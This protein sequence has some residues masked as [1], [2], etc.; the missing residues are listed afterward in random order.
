MRAL[1]V[2]RV[3][4]ASSTTSKTNQYGKTKQFCGSLL[5]ESATRF[6]LAPAKSGA[7]TGDDLAVSAIG[8]G[9]AGVAQLLELV[10][11]DG[12]EAPLG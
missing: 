7:V 8:N 1:T 4:S 3:R 11:F 9:L 10:L 12:G 2:A 5:M 6:S